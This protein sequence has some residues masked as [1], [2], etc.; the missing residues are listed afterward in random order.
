MYIYIYIYIYIYKSSQGGAGAEAD[1]QA[2][3]QLVAA[4]RVGR[5]RQLRFLACPV[6]I[7]RILNI[8]IHAEIKHTWN[9]IY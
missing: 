3:E 8:N 7:H 6:C 1:S 5:S 2:R 4:G 9:Y